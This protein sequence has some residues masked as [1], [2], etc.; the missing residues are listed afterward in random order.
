MVEF[1]LL[2][3]VMLLFVFGIFEFGRF[4]Y[5]QNQ[6]Q[7]AVEQTARQ[8]LISAPA[9]TSCTTSSSNTTAVTNNL[10]GLDPTSVTVTLAS[11]TNGGSGLATPPK[12]CTITA[13][14]AFSFLGF[15]QLSGITAQGLAEF[16]CSA[17]NGC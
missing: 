10:A 3:P 2:L 4:F 9:I 5:T 1:A 8:S 16:P 7:Y 13:T 6:L 11:A 15:L 12:S 14:Y 17:G